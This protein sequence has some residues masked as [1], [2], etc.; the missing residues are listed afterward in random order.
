M[1]DALALAI[2]AR[3]AKRS[4]IYE[5]VLMRGLKCIAQLQYRGRADAFYVERPQRVVGGVRTEAYDNEIRI[6]NIQ[7]ALMGLL[8]LR[9]ILS[10]RARGP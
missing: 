2:E 3:D 4:A 7:H 10:G 9:A 6:D 1:A 5:R 8:K